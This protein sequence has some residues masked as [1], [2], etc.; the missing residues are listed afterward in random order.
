M[1]TFCIR[2]TCLPMLLAAQSDSNVARATK[3]AL[4]L[5]LVPRL[6]AVPSKST[7]QFSPRA[8]V[9]FR[10]FPKRG[11]ASKETLAFGVMGPEIA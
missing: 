7:E 11:Q 6:F 1:K 8:F 5:L 10:I 9:H 4:L 3:D 2:N